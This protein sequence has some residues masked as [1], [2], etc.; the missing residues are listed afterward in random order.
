MEDQDTFVL[1]AAEADDDRVDRSV[2]TGERAE[3]ARP[4]TDTANGARD[5]PRDD[6]R[7][8]ELPESPAPDPEEGDKPRPEDAPTAD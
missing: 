2:Q 6:D 3:P 5:V 1:R 4:D 7:N 8:E